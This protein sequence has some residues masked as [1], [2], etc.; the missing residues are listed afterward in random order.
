MNKW[1]PACRIEE[2]YNE[3]RAK[4]LE[5]VSEVLRESKFPH[6]TQGEHQDN[7]TWL[8]DLITVAFGAI[9]EW[10]RR[11][12]SIYDYPAEYYGE[13]TCPE[14]VWWTLRNIQDKPH[15]TASYILDLLKGKD[16]EI[17]ALR[18]ELY[19]KDVEAKALRRQLGEA[20][21]KNRR[22]R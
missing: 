10:E 15:R 1:K 4:V 13:E 8:V 11:W 5:E 19:R 9:A 3:P 16:R 2:S 12:S 6:T 14:A 22:R 20:R 21:R 7:T 18:K 17:E